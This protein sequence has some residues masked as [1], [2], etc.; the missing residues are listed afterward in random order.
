MERINKYLAAAG[1]G[2]RRGVEKLIRDGLILIN[3]QKATLT[4]NVSNLDIIKVNNKTI[5]KKNIYMLH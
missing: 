5:T 3:D 1:I 4:S 2:S